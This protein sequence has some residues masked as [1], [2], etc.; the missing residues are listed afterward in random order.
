MDDKLLPFCCKSD[1]NKEQLR[2]YLKRK[3]DS[4]SDDKWAESFIKLFDLIDQALEN[5]K[6]HLSN[7]Q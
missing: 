6:N 7:Y 2:E 3:A 4:Q 5:L 1:S